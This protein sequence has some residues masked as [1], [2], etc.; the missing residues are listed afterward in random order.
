MQPTPL[1]FLLLLST[2]HASLDTLVVFLV[3]VKA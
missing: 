3:A 2:Y 1:P